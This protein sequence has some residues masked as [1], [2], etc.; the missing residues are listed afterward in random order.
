MILDSL[1]ALAPILIILL[2]MLGFRW[3]A[4]RAGPVGWASAVVIAVL[5]FGTGF[6]ILALAQSKAF[7][8]TLD[9]LLIV[10][11]AFLLYRASTYPGMGGGRSA[12]GLIGKG[13]RLRR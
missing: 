11:G 1:L 4:A 6:E 2:L 7:L 9:V 5:R 12:A 13:G 8:L 3:G 10:W